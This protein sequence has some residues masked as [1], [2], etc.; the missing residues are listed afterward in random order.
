MSWS[1]LYNS[2]RQRA[3]VQCL[4]VVLAVV[5][6]GYCI[7]VHFWRR[8][9]TFGC[10]G[11]YS[12]SSCPTNPN[13]NPTTATDQ[14]DFVDSGELTHLVGHNQSCDDTAMQK[15]E[16]R[17]L[18][19]GDIRRGERVYAKYKSPIGDDKFYP[20]TVIRVY[21][22]D[23]TNNLP[24]SATKYES[25]DS[26]F[27]E[28]VLTRP[29]PLFY[30]LPN[31]L[32]YY[33]PDFSAS[34]QLHNRL[35]VQ[36]MRK[37]V[38]QP[39]KPMKTL[40][41]HSLSPVT[42]DTVKVDVMFN[43]QSYNIA[44]VQSA[45][46][47]LRLTV[48]TEVKR[49]P[50]SALVDQCAREC[51]G[52]YAK[53]WGVEVGSCLTKSCK[54]QCLVPDNTMSTCTKVVSIESNDTHINDHKLVDLH[55][56]DRAKSGQYVM[57]KRLTKSCG[58]SHGW[59]QPQ[60][61]SKSCVLAGTSQSSSSGTSCSMAPCSQYSDNTKEM[62]LCMDKN[63]LTAFLSET[64]TVTSMGEGAPCSASAD[65]PTPASVC[66]QNADIPCAKR[67]D[68]N[69]CTARKDADFY[70]CGWHEHNKDKVMDKYA[71]GCYDEDKCVLLVTEE[72]CDLHNKC[73]WD[74]T[75][76]ICTDKPYCPSMCTQ[77]T[78][79]VDCKQ[80]DVCRWNGNK[81]KIKTLTDKEELR[82]QMAQP[83]QSVSTGHSI[84]RDNLPTVLFT[85]SSKPVITP[86][87]TNSVFTDF[88]Q[89]TRE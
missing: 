61:E 63:K 86:A 56:I 32:F 24:S 45:E 71:T 58:S 51:L 64:P 43:N 14:P 31:P 15:P 11:T 17:M 57:H 36:D 23:N 42:G 25:A 44:R 67:A 73:A 37:H 82:Q 53:T 88:Q 77:K 55:Q 66:S 38:S 85:H 18:D 9:E 16:A 19:N 39:T 13:P 10:A 89:L 7:C 62:E 26:A 69:T 84:L 29:N 35:T 3:V 28:S 59:V 30:Y 81:C 22:A 79:E 70:K 75:E 21:R 33:L 50:Q 20:A 78:T 87:L 4:C 74:K 27:S 65:G 6:V 68:S 60:S 1:R 34:A 72:A 76:G 48:G 80:L 52:T 54:C 47:D 41:V 5:F 83:A 2:T 12:H 49:T 8:V 46:Q 40:G